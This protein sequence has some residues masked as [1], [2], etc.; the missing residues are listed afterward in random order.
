MCR[1]IEH[2]LFLSM[3]IILEIFPDGVICELG[4]QDNTVFL[5]DVNMLVKR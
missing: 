2:R 3:Y 4:L 1:N 5:Y